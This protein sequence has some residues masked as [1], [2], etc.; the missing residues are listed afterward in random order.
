VD[1]IDLE[2]EPGSLLH[3]AR[4]GRLRAFETWLSRFWKRPVR[5]PAAYVE[6]LTAF[7]GGVPGKKCFRTA[8]GRV[9]VLGR[10][11]NFLEEEDLDPPLVPTWRSWGGRQDIRLDYRVAEYLDNEH[12]AIRI[13]QFSLLPFAGLDTAGHDCRAMDDYD[14]LCFD[15]D[16][17]DE[18]PVV[19]WDFHGSWEG[20]AVT[21]AVATS[22]GEFL[23]LLYRGKNRVAKEAVETF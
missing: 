20:R 1:A 5:L 13:D 3:P 2:C 10:F 14:L 16:G 21:E 18:P 23:P 7:H 17:G 4:R 6:H 19:A 22:F 12:W 8:S 15:Y 11:F 9:R